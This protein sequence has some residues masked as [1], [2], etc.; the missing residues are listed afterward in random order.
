LLK[1]INCD[2]VQERGAPNMATSTEETPVDR[3]AHDVMPG[4]PQ[5]PQLLVRGQ[6]T[7]LVAFDATSWTVQIGARLNPGQS[8]VVRVDGRSVVARVLTCGVDRIERGGVTYRA[9]LAAGMA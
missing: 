7:T 3:G 5:A 9:C 1:T 2:A 4:E 8:I 6:A